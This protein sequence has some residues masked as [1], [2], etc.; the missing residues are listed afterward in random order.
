MYDLR[1]KQVSR[2]FKKP[3]SVWSGS[4]IVFRAPPGTAMK[5]ISQEQTRIRENM[6]R[7]GQTS[8]LYNR[9]VKKLD[10]QETE[11]EKLRKE[12]EAL[13]G[14]EEEQTR[15]LQDHLMGLDMS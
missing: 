11:M 8:E 10:Q 14:T 1:A 5:E 15:E 2:W 9:Y 7:L 12:I 13:Q 3:C 4:A 6:G